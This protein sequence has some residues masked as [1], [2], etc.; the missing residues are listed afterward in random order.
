[1]KKSTIKKI[2]S[3]GYTVKRIDTGNFRGFWGGNCNHIVVLL[4]KEG[5]ALSLDGIK[6]FA[7]MGKAEGF[8]FLLENG[9]WINESWLKI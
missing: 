1:M 3:Y 8:L 5:F 7:P 4:N 9:G 2:E 6:P